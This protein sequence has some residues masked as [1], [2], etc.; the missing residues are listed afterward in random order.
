MTATRRRNVLK[1]VVH[2]QS[3]FV[4]VPKSVI[5]VKSCS[6]ANQTYRYFDVPVAFKQSSLLNPM[7]RTL[8]A[9]KRVAIHKI[10][11]NWETNRDV[12]PISKALNAVL[13]RINVNI[14]IVIYQLFLR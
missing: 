13:T 10:F 6:F 5:H 3:C 14:F 7:T 12:C 1:S 11:M 8:L 4:N 9:R 2:V